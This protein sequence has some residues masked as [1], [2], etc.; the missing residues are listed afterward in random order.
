MRHAFHFRQPQAHSAYWLT[1]QKIHIVGYR[2][3]MAIAVHKIWS[4]VRR[5]VAKSKQTRL[6]RE[7]ALRGVKYSEA[8]PP[9]MPMNLSDK[10]E[11]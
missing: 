6:D 7:L 11:F 9:R 4:A 2:D 3:G 8:H 1:H 5:S 10:W